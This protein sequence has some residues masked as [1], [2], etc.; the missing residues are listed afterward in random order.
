MSKEKSKKKSSNKEKYRQSETVVIKRSQI[1]FAPYNPKSHTKEQVDAIRK[2]IKRVAFLG[3]IV[4]NLTT[5]NLIDGHKRVTALDFIHGYDGSPEKDYD[6]KVEQIELDE[7]TE[8]EQNVF[9]TKSRTDLDNE[10]LASIVLEGIEIEN[11]GLTIEDI[12]IIELEVPDFDYGANTEAKEGFGAI[13]KKEVTAEEHQRN[14]DKIKEA[15]QRTKNKTEGGRFLTLTFKSFQ[16][17][18]EFLELLGFDPYAEY[19]PGEQVDQK[20][21]DM[22]NV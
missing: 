10:L 6:I 19:I 5:G 17:K 21:Q 2:N 7:K 14:V 3:G 12:H 1:H 4:Y 16:E 13:S 15:K 9:Q 8:K 20:I 22:L 11:A 18:A